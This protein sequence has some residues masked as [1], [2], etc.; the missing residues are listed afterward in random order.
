MTLGGTEVVGVAVD[1]P[2]DVSP[3]WPY[4]RTY[5]FKCPAFISFYT[6]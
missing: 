6:K 5:Y 4:E 1:G 3:L 2:W